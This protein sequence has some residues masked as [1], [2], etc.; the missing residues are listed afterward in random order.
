MDIAKQ[1]E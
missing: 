1:I